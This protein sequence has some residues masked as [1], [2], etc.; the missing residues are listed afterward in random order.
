MF[1]YLDFS[2]L[3]RRW[4]AFLSLARNSNLFLGLARRGQ[5][6]LVFGARIVETGEKGVEGGEELVRIDCLLGEDQILIKRV[7]LF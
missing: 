7:K 1:K 5:A 4:D 2:Y 6:T 3:W